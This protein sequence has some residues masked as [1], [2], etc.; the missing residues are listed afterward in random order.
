MYTFYSYIPNMLIYIAD[1]YYRYV[2]TF[3]INQAGDAVVIWK[4]FWVTQ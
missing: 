1:T 4:D 3:S 2:H